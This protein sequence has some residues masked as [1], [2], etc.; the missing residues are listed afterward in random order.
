M[1]NEPLLSASAT[2]GWRLSGGTYDSTSA[3]AA[4]VPAT[5][6]KTLPVILLAGTVGPVEKKVDAPVFRT[7]PRMSDNPF[8]MITVYAVLARHPCSGLTAMTSRCHD[9]RATPSRGDMRNR[10]PSVVDPVGRSETTSSK[11]NSTSLG[12]TPTLPESGTILTICGAATSGGP[13]GGM[14]GDAHPSP[15]S[16]TAVSR[17]KAL[18]PF[19][20]SVRDV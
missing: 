12:L 16:T 18:L 5:Q 7:L 15:S 8:S 17:R 19:P 6:S 13:P 20:R 14:P 1:V 2:Y 9:A 11:R 3:P 4:G 10:S